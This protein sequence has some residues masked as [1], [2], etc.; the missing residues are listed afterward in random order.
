MI[1]VVLGAV[2][3]F[4]CWIDWNHLIG[5]AILLSSER[6]LTNPHR[7][8]TDWREALAKKGR[9]ILSCKLSWC[10]FLNLVSSLRRS[11]TTVAFDLNLRTPLPLPYNSPPSLSHASDPVLS[12]LLITIRLPFKLTSILLYESIQNLIATKTK[13]NVTLISSRHQVEGR[14]GQAFTG[15][16]LINYSISFGFSGRARSYAMMGSRSE[17]PPRIWVWE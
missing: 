5:S 11:R 6:M 8:N 17:H 10:F 12:L 2:I 1:N 4:P 13:G 16:R 15:Q 14:E 7:H 3:P 9:P